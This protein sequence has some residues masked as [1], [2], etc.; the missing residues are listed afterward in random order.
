[1]L[2]PVIKWLHILAAIAAL[3]S[4]LTY[5]I[6]LSY[7]EREEKALAFALRGIQRLDQRLANPSYGVLLVTGVLMVLLARLPLTLPWLLVALVLYVLTAL[8]GIF[9]YAPLLR[10][11]M[12]LAE[13]AGPAS[14][15]YRATAVRS[16]QLGVLTIVI[17]AAIVFL[18]VVKPTLW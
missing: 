3:G 15:E 14:P 7:A 1:M 9:A 13:T 5:G 17:V 6:W 4:N 2:Y 8:L 18:M 16:L 12:S 10:R 11:Q